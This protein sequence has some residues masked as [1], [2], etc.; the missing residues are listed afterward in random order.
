[1]EFSVRRAAVPSTGHRAQASKS[2]P[3]AAHGRRDR[4]VRCR[5]P[6]RTGRHRGSACGYD[7]NPAKPSRG[8]TAARG[9]DG[10]AQFRAQEACRHRRILR[11]PVCR[12]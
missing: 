10:Q 6:T 12:S 7:S 5:A 2:S 11:A 3:E 9:S 8:R 1:L 4:A